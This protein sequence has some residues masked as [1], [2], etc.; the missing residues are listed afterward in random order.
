MVPLFGNLQ[1]PVKDNSS[2][3]YTAVSDGIDLQYTA[4]GSGVK[5]DIILTKPIEK[6]SFSYELKSDTPPPIYSRR[7]CA[8][9][10][11]GK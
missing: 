4:K 6:A 3:R 5:E 7:Q 10:L 2:V 11:L 9:R 8:L 1:N